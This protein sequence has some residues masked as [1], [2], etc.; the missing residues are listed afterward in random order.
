V[1][2]LAAAFGSGAMT[3]TIACVEEA[4]VILIT[5]SNTT[6]NH[7]VLSAGVKRAVASGRARL[8][9][10]DPRRIKIAEFAE[11][12]LRPNLGT[13]VAWINGMMHVIIKENLHD[14]Q[15]VEDRTENFEALKAVVEKYT[16]EYVETITG[17]P[18]QQLMDAARLYAGGGVGS[19]LYCMGITQHTSGTDNVKSLANLAMLCGNLGMRGGG[20]NPLRGQN[21]VQGACDMGGLPN[22]FT[23][24]QP[25]NNDDASQKMAAAWNVE[26]LST[27]IGMKATE[28]IPAA[29][30]GRLKAL[31][32]I[33]EN[34]MVAD[35][36]LNHAEDCL[37]HLDLMVVQD[38]FMTETARKAD[39]VLPS[40]CFA[41]K[42]GTFSNTERRVQR[43]RKAVEAP[44]EAW[45]DWKIVAEL[46]GRMG[47]PM[48]YADSEAIF[49]EIRQVTPSYAGITYHRIEMEGLHWPC[50]NEE[51]PGTPVLH[52][53]QFTRGKGMFHAIDWQP[54]AEV[55]DQEYP[56]YLTTGRILY[57]YHT[58][59]MTMRSEDLME[60]APESFVEISPQDATAFGVTDGGRVSIA[61]RRGQIEARV[62]ISPKAVTGTV[63]IP[64]HY[65]Q[66][67]ANKLTNAALDP[68]SGIPEYKVCAVKLQPVS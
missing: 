16:P 60:R 43:V 21:N 29:H 40:R 61:S 10:V 25:V 41:E 15:F 51:H 37:E 46:S 33:G 6:E 52:G 19:I 65:A 14:K 35:P 49:E 27:S 8:I 67:A 48:D 57:H 63:F 62:K 7:P 13:D 23:A 3:N 44:G 66:G 9:V 11:T 45:D 47:Y 38:L 4:D 36:D 18:A 5:G 20:V 68:I 30:D 24:Y 56:L 17:I 55:P 50:L 12:Y 58:G 54:P 22:V 64:F 59:T 39:V 2:G 53:V 42:D 1:A 34:P 32:V 26:G 28:M 31:Y